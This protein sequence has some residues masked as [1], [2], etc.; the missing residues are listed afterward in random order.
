MTFTPQFYYF[1]IIN[2]FLCRFW[3]FFS[4][5]YVG[6]NKR[7]NAFWLDQLEF[8]TMIGVVVELW[9]RFVWSIIRVENEFFNNFE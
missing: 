3:W 9:R 6:F 5:F 2:N 1:A 7:D 4:S 8:M